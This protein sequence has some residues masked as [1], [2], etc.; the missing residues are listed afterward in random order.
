MPLGFR[1]PSAARSECSVLPATG[2]KDVMCCIPALLSGAEVPTISATA[3]KMKESL[4]RG[5][6]S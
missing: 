3:S 5:S 1:V 2:S 4:A 6:S